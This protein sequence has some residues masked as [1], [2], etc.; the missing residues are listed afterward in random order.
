[1]HVAADRPEKILAAAEHVEFVAIEHFA[2]D[3][4]LRLA[5]AIDVFGDPEQRVQ[6]AQPALAVLHVRLDQITRLAGAAMALL[7]LGE[8]GGDEFRR[9]ALHDF[10]F[11]ARGQ[12]AVERGI[13]EQ[14]PRLEQRRADGHVGLG[15]AD[16]FADRTGGV[17]DLLPHV[18]QAIEQCFGDR[19]APGGLLVGQ[20]EQQ[21][22]VG[23]RRQQAAAIAAGGD[24]RHALGL[25]MDLRRVKRADHE[26]EQDADDFVLGLTQPLGATAA[27]A[28][29]EQQFLGAGARLH[30]R[31]LEAARHGGAQFALAPGMGFGEGFEVG[32]DGRAVDQFGGDARRPLEYQASLRTVITEP[33][34]AVMGPHV[35]PA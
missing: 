33:C 14:M 17:A 15:L 26:F 9:G 18:P 25:R 22:D 28:V 27:V 10:L 8:L 12:L 7:A 31:R 19:F 34:C 3:Q 1:M 23:A 24:H 16:A 2:I 11:E 30:Q 5:H 21:I 13:A 35:A 4:F 32:D 6:V 29:L 20:H